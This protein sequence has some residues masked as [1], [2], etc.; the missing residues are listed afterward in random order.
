MVLG[1]SYFIRITL[2]W[3]DNFRLYFKSFF[4]GGGLKEERSCQLFSR[5]N[6]TSGSI[7]LGELLDLLREG[8]VL[9]KI[10]YLWIYF[11]YCRKFGDAVP[12]T[13]KYSPSL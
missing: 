2:R 5:R 10:Y 12:E 1:L 3:K 9:E 6:E 7:K 4:L 11:V 13:S 8:K